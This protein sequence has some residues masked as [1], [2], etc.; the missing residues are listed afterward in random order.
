MQRQGAEMSHLLFMVHKKYHTTFGHVIPLSTDNCP[1]NAKPIM[2]V[3]KKPM[4]I[5]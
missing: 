1:S 5:L 3:I 2:N 4:S